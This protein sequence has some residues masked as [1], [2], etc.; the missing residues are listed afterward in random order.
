MRRLMVVR[1]GLVLLLALG[2]QA[3][4]FGAAEWRSLTEGYGW[5]PC[6]EVT[7]HIDVDSLPPGVSEATLR[8]DLERA[9]GLINA[10]IGRTMVRVAPG[11]TTTDP[12][13]DDEFN[14]V[15][16]TSLVSG[17]DPGSVVVQGYAAASW[18]EYDD[19]TGEIVDADIYLDDSDWAEAPEGLRTITLA[20]EYGHALGLDHVGDAHEIMSYGYRDDGDGLGPG[21][22]QAL[23]A[24]YAGA[25]CAN[26][27]RLEDS[28]RWDGLEP[29]GPRALG[30]QAGTTAG[31]VRALAIE[32]GSRLGQL[33][34]GGQW[35]EHA[36]VCRADLYPDCLAGA[37]LAGSTGPIVYVPGGPSGQLTTSDP[38]FQFLASVLPQNA[39]VYV[40]GGD[41]AVSEQIVQTLAARWPAT[42]RVWGQTRFET[43]VA[44][45]RR[46]VAQGAD[47]GTVLLAR[48]DNP[49]DAVT[50]GAAAAARGIPTLLTASG[51]LHPATRALLAEFATTRTLVLGGEVA[52]APAVQ[53]TLA[54]DGRGP[55]RLAGRTRTETSVAI[56]R[57]PATW[58]RTSV[59]DGQAFLAL[60]GWH[61]ETWAVALVSAPL[62]A[63][64]EAPVLLTRADGVPYAAPA[65]GY[66]GDTGWYLSHLSGSGTVQ[67]MFV[68]VGRWADPHARDSFWEYIGLY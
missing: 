32:M 22:R 16:F 53:A 14:V 17:D 47:G 20:H 61:E 30:L 8:A 4:A 62:A 39:P 63:L 6:A 65:D 24:M 59:T 41:Q 13:G 57:H 5:A 3:A 60:N 11:T 2:V 56:A 48:S 10:E 36:V 34:G 31:D 18:R 19:G 49:A 12:A 38:T 66:P 33:R 43:A 25:D 21:T 27:R 55:E 40:L 54:Q 68:G 58:G 29:D 50:A 64:V 67:A 15:H 1:V 23:R 42:R 7:F 35:A 28:H 26:L 46:L 51:S 9:A 44:I 45:A 52:I 37:A